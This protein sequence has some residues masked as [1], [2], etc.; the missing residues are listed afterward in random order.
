MPHQCDVEQ[1]RVG[2]QVSQVV[3][4]TVAAVTTSGP[5]GAPVRAPLVDDAAHAGSDDRGDLVVPHPA[6]EGPG[7]GEHDGAAIGWTRLRAARPVGVPFDGQASQGTAGRSDHARIRCPYEV[8]YRSRGRFV[9][10]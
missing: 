4:E 2:G 9:P 1:L 5:V 3:G 7:M 10:S 6:G 8:Q